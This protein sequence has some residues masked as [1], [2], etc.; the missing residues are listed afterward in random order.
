MWI[1]ATT[2]FRRTPRGRGSPRRGCPRTPRRDHACGVRV[3]RYAVH[4]DERYRQRVV[5]PADLDNRTVGPCPWMSA[6]MP[7]P[8][9]THGADAEH[10][11]PGRRPGVPDALLHRQPELDRR[12]RGLRTPRP[13]GTGTLSAGP[14][15]RRHRAR[16]P[17]T[18]APAPWGPSSATSP[19][20][21]TRTGQGCV[22]NDHGETAATVITP[23]PSTSSTSAFALHRRAPR[24]P[25]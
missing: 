20:P 1:V 11:F 17:P 16:W 13:A 21:A 5:A 25:P 12:A 24:H 9:A 2:P 23:S 19:D 22:L 3:E 6:P 15:G 8:I 18:W 4:H 10:V 14:R 7:M